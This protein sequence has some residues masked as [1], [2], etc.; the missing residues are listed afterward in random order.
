MASAGVDGNFKGISQYSAE[1]FKS[2]NMNAPLF[3]TRAGGLFPVMKEKCY[4]KHNSVNSTHMAM[5]I[6]HTL[7]K[8]RGGKYL[9]TE[10]EK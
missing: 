1:R 9:F 10:V 5:N 4:T 6:Q 8:F 3:G 7:Q 2:F